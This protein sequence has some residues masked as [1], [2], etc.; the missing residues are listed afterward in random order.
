MAVSEQFVVRSRGVI[1][2]A[3][4]LLVVRHAHDP[5]FAALPGGH[6]EFGESPRACVER[7]LWEELGVRPV[8]G[9]LLYV[10]TFV[11]TRAGIRQQPVEFFFEITNAADFRSVGEDRSHAHELAAIEWVSPGH[12]VT[13]LPSR[14]GIDLAA[15]LLLSDE[16]RFVAD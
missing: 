11:T 15:G 3:G 12:S 13:I 10:N 1:L 2:D 9:R 16:P 6:L 14:I 8:V 5:S 4:E 7:E